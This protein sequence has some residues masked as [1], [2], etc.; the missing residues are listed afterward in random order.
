MLIRN[1]LTPGLLAD[2][3]GNLDSWGWME[4]DGQL[5][6]F[7]VISDNFYAAGAISPKA[8]HA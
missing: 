2:S 1:K 6:L 5:F 8:G 4:Q 3:I 7:R